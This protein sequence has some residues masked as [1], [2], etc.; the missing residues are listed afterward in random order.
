MKVFRFAALAWVAVACLFVFSLSSRAQEAEPVLVEHTYD[1]SGLTR[2]EFE[3]TPR[4][5]GI[6]DVLAPDTLFSRNGYEPRQ[7]RWSLRHSGDE[8]RCWDY[9]SDTLQSIYSFCNPEQ[10]PMDFNG[11]NPAD[12]QRVKVTTTAE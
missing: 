8:A 3:R 6:G 7:D 2:A 5:G 12:G 11:A 1:F 10:L 9:P 4:S